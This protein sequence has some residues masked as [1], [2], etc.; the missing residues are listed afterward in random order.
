LDQLEAD[1]RLLFRR[2]NWTGIHEAIPS[3]IE[4]E[5]NGLALSNGDLVMQPLHVSRL[6]LWRWRRRRNRCK[7]ERSYEHC[8]HVT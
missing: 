6:I 7:H 2:A 3:L 8:F 5:Q 1:G 4:C